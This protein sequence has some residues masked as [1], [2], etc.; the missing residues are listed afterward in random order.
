MNVWQIWHEA[1]PV[2][3]D[4]LLLSAVALT[5]IGLGRLSLGGVRL[6][7]AGVL[8]S[9]LIASHFGFRPDHGV[10]HFIKEFG[11]M[12]FVFTLGLQMG[13]GF[14]ASLRQEGL[15]LNLYATAIIGS[16]AVITLAGAKLL[17]LPMAAA[18][19]VFAGG[20]T[21]TPALGA[22]QQA[23]AAT[24]GGDPELAA[25]AYAAAY[26]LAVVGI[27]GSLM[28]LKYW[29]RVDVEGEA[30]AFRTRQSEGVE[31]LERM[32]LVVENPN[33][34]GVEV[35]AV[36]GL[37]ETG[38]VV[39]RLRKSG[40]SDAVTA[41]PHTVLHLGDTFV[42]V[43]THGHLEQ[44]R[45]VVGR[46]AGEDLMQ[47]PG[48]VTFRRVVL[49]NKKLLGK[50]VGSLGLDLLYGVTVTRVSRQDHAFT[51]L[52]DLPLQFGDMLQIVGDE[53]SLDQATK[54]LGNAVHL[55]N[56]TNFAPVFA[57]FALGVLLGLYPIEVSWLPAPLRL[58]LAGG[59]LLVAILISR[60]GRI[61]PL[62]VHMPLN[63]NRALKD[64][65]IILFLACVGLL[66]GEN[67]FRTVFTSQGLSW[68]ALGAAVTLLPLLI[69]GSIGRRFHKMNF[70]TLS[71]LLSGSMTDPPALAFATGMARCDSPAISYATVYPLTMI[72]RI[73]LAQL[74]ALLVL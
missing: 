45:K 56:E 29:F 46:V 39:S 19:G 16:G 13:P 41:G 35:I 58:G 72:L 47:A 65:G 4:L 5:G 50:T 49:T 43:G 10:A 48:R 44:F 33:L 24:A 53:P 8:F 20:T 66:A 22:A 2:A 26:P 62:V 30:E 70:M 32:S 34:D 38:V 51:A 37:K 54:R 28:F 67:F 73:V 15:K 6:G 68:V 7:V 21:N 23:L 11:L 14:F 18:A 25:M 57:G 55:L 71:G 42:A 69:V 40:E 17:G 61:G 1:H 60:L 3:L 9:G 64:L 59:P 12:L 52:P 74:I 36:P 63:T 27:I 31:P